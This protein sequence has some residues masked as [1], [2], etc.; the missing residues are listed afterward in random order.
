MGDII[1]FKNIDISKI[2]DDLFDEIENYLKKS[3]NN[4]VK[5]VMGKSQFFKQNR[6][7]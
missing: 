1:P 7:P 5:K 2:S 6:M 4:E 3:F